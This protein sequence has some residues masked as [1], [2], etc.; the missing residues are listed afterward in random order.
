MKTCSICKKNKDVS[1]FRLS[2]QIKSGIDSFCRECDKVISLKYYYDNHE[3]ALQRARER[4]QKNKKAKIADST[5][6]NK[7]NPLKT[8]ARRDVN[9]AI[10]RQKLNRLPCEVCGNKNSHA[11]HEDYSKPLEIRWLCQ[12]HHSEVHRKYNPRVLIASKT[13][14]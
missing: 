1:E 10:C 9:H 4:Y 2:K 6:R 14:I 3:K 12:K 7:T 13:A 11:H 5:K 8:K